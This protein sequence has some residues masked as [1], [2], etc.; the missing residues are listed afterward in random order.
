MNISAEIAVSIGINIVA[1][2]Y[3]A[4]V[5]SE[6]QKNVKESI[7]HLKEDFKEKIEDMKKDFQDRFNLLEK[8]QDKHNNLIE[9]MARVEDSTKSAHK[10]INELTNCGYD[11]RE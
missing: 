11:D 9:R 7:S 5:H 8:K 10:R 6:G 1:I 2:A 3:F 4:G